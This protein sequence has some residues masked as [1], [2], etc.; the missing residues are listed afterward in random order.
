MKENN[1]TNTLL[2]TVIGVATLLVAVIGATFAYF[3]ATIGGTESSTTITVGAGSLSIAYSG[4]ANITVDDIIPTVPVCAEG[5]WTDSPTNSKCA[6][7]DAT[8]VAPLTTKTFTVTGNNNTAGK[9]PYTIGLVVQT[10]GFTANTLKYTLES[11][12]TSSNGDVAASVSTW[13]GIPTGA[14][15]IDFG[16]GYFGANASGAIHTYKL[17]IYFPDTYTNQDTDK[18]KGFTAYVSTSTSQITQ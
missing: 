8:T 1:K 7:I 14:N 18:A 10:N 6:N 4:G 12:N 13:V 3:T 5:P 9:M 11:I 17:K 15:T 2:L 16:S